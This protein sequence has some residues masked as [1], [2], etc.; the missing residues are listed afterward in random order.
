MV[1]RDQIAPVAKRSAAATTK[2]TM[3]ATPREVAIDAGME[4]APDHDRDG[5]N[6]RWVGDIG[7][8][9]LA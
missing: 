9:Q 5:G 8:G 7:R 4:Q 6:S 2:S 3:S 1:L